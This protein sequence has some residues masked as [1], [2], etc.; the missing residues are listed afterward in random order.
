MGVLAWRGLHERDDHGA[1]RPWRV[2]A[3]DVTARVESLEAEVNRQRVELARARADISELREAVLDLPLG[4]TEP[5][6]AA[7]AGDPA[8]STPEAQ[9]AA[10]EAEWQKLTDQFSSEGTDTRWDP[11][12]ELSRKI[13]AVMQPGGSL[14]SLDCRASM[15]RLET[16]HPSQDSYSD[17]TQYFT[18]MKGDAQLWTGSTAL[19]VTHE[20]EHDGDPLVAVAYLHRGS[21][22]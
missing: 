12:P 17:F 21:F 7:A 3:G 8:V 10:Y 4:S 1:A 9:D 19:R 13:L 18:L 6:A 22:N 16:S 15:C 2:E 5:V 20:P 14:R 11:S